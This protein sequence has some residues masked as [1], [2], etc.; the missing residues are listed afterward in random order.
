MI[1][2][3]ATRT[4]VTFTSVPTGLAV[5]AAGRPEAVEVISETIAARTRALGFHILGSVP[6]HR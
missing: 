6:L 2:S 5:A 4:H 1:H 3:Q